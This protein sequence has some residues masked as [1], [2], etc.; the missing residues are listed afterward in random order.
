MKH[1]WQYVSGNSWVHPECMGDQELKETD[2]GQHVISKLE[3]AG[4]LA[5]GERQ[6]SRKIN[7]IYWAFDFIQVGE[8]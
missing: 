7:F 5:A 2:R 4:N 1:S 8:K 3:T 6:D